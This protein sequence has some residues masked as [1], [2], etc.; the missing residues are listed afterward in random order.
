MYASQVF[1]SVSIAIEVPPRAAPPEEAITVVEVKEPALFLLPIATLTSGVDVSREDIWGILF[2]S[3]WISTLAEPLFKVAT[4]ILV[5][6]QK[7]GRRFLYI[8]VKEPAKVLL[9]VVAIWG[10]LFLSTAIATD[11]YTTCVVVGKATCL[12]PYVSVEVV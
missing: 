4:V 2:W 9:L 11:P 8:V 12:E 3:I 5:I 10:M 7:P 1:P 6:F